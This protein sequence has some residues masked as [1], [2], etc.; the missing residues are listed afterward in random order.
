VI[1]KI[2]LVTAEP[3]VAN[4]MRP[5]R[6]SRPSKP[7]VGQNG[8]SNHTNRSMRKA[9]KLKWFDMTVTAGHR[10]L[11]RTWWRVATIEGIPSEAEIAETL[12]DPQIDAVRYLQTR[13]AWPEF[14]EARA[15]LTG[16][17]LHIP[18][19]PT[20]CHETVISEYQGPSPK[21]KS[22]MRSQRV[23]LDAI[24]GGEKTIHAGGIDDSLLCA[25][26]WVYRRIVPTCWQRK[27]LNNTRAITTE[28]NRVK[29]LG[30]AGEL[31][32]AILGESPAVAV[33][34]GRL[35]DGVLRVERVAYN[36][37]YA[38]YS[39]GKLLIHEVIDW[40]KVTGKIT[41]IDWGWGD[42]DYKQ[43]FSTGWS[44]CAN[45]FFVRKTLR[46]RVKLAID[47]TAREAVRILKWV[48]GRASK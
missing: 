36:E 42:N 12:N 2:V 7:K 24:V 8:F 28:L 34:R 9:A 20:S 17:L 43:Q 23:K 38:T 6:P 3:I 22:A 1:S 39:P 31:F 30:E 26:S 45:V 35:R 15:T 27:T 19:E 40:A 14:Y 21:H 47:A 16:T 25:Y 32:V 37:D 13:W 11:C 46:N 44:K 48:K 4:E 33:I 5:S 41:R 18:D 29:A 10:V